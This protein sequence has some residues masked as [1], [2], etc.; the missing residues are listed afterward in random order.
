VVALP[1]FFL[2]T[3]MGLMVSMIG[4]VAMDLNRVFGVIMSL[5]MWAT[6]LIYS[7]KVPNK[8]LQVAM[9]WNPVAYLV[10]SCREMVLYGRLYKPTG[11]F[12]AA[13][14]SLVLF[15]LSWRMFYVSE[16]K[17]VERMV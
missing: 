8:L 1:L 15:L 5:M 14:I 12:I 2:G 3:A 17:L 4:I 13:G 9:K 11:Y 6:P 16:D 10:C 7:D